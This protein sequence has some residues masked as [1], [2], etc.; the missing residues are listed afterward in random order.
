MVVEDD[1]AQEEGDAG[2][3][4]APGFDDVMLKRGSRPQVT[5]RTEPNLAL[6]TTRS[7][8]GRRTRSQHPGD[9]GAP[10][11][12]LSSVCQFLQ[13]RCVGRR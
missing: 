7:R 9:V 3:K 1:E 6:E 2:V 10:G 5:S 4:H 8:S 11:C 12:T 13:C